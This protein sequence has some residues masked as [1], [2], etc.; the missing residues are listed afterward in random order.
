MSGELAY[1]ESD[2]AVAEDAYDTLEN[3]IWRINSMSSLASALGC[4]VPTN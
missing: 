1:A 2:V 3:A 4:D